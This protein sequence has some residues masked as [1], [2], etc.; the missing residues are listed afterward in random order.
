MTNK[1]V[2]LFDE[3]L[4]EAGKDYHEA[5]QG[6]VTVQDRMPYVVRRL[7]ERIAA[8]EGRAPARPNSELE[9]D[10]ANKRLHL[11]IDEAEKERDELRLQVQAKS[12]LNEQIHKECLGLR[13][14][15]QDAE[16]DALQT[17][18]AQPYYDQLL[19]SVGG[20]PKPEVETAHEQLESTAKDR[21]RWLLRASVLRC[22]AMAPNPKGESDLARCVLPRGHTGEH[23]PPTERFGWLENAE[24]MDDAL[25]R[26]GKNVAKEAPS[27]CSTGCTRSNCGEAPVP[28]GTSMDIAVG[29]KLGE[30]RM[31]L[32]NEMHDALT[33]GE[34]VTDRASRIMREQRD[35]IV[36]L[37]KNINDTVTLLRTPG[38]RGQITDEVC[39]ILCKPFVHEKVKP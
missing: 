34:F 4:N 19:R 18:N 2:P 13:K 24:Q 39:D 26:A 17:K 21:G 16:D 7:C 35:R 15:L 25:R 5:Y 12:D 28:E 9:L 22:D 27:S 6:K 3:L 38:A 20:T 23:L 8:M 33:P 31:V 1:Q 11:A 37:H 36:H 32:V 30:L 29:E 10:I 14:R